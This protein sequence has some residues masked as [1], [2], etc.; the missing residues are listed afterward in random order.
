MEIGDSITPVCSAYSDSIRDN[1]EE[2]RTR[3]NPFKLKTFIEQASY[4][5]KFLSLNRELGTK[6]VLVN[7]PLTPDNM[8]LM[9]AGLYN[10]YLAKIRSLANKYQAEVLDFNSGTFFSRKEF[11]DTAHLN[12]LGGEK[13]AQLVCN[14]ISQYWQSSNDP[15]VKFQCR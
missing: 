10:S 14:R 13:L 9:P 3:Y 5:E 7:M 1:S 8:H 4:L 6:V 2:Y 15:S 11:C 12:G